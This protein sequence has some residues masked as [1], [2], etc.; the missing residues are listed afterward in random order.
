MLKS[1]DVL[2]RLDPVHKYAQMFPAAS[3]EAVVQGPV[4]SKSETHCR[5]IAI[6]LLTT[7]FYAELE[8]T[9]YSLNSSEH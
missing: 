7:N 3:T 5:I 9:C 1:L 6:Y 2:S 8:N 4:S